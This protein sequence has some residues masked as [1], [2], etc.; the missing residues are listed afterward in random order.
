[1]TSDYDQ[2]TLLSLSP[3]TAQ[4]L[5][6]IVGAALAITFVIWSRTRAKPCPGAVT[7]EFHPPLVE[8]GS[9]HIQLSWPGANPCRFTVDLPLDAQAKDRG[10]TGCGM[11]LELRTQVRDG[12]VSV[13]GLTFAAAPAQF[14]LQVKRD[15]EPIYDAQLEPK[16]AP[17]ATTRAEDKHFCGERALVQAP[18]LRGSSACAPFPA[19]CTGP[20]DCEAKRACC[21]T[22]EWGRDFGPLSAS[23][24]TS[25]NSCLSHLGHLACRDDNDCPSAMRCA[26]ASL[27]AE[28][29]KPVLV[30]R[31]R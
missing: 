14:G 30:C 4:R 22:P 8:R 5:G 13:A 19:R 24:C 15:A 26:D 2:A 20:Q 16:F 18:C 23:E 7:L 21:L 10:K 12:R 17:Y 1:M 9:Y 3:S 31:D 6:A 25:S 29:S 11:A 27:A 28:F